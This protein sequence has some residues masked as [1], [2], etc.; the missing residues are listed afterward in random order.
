MNL[1]PRV[2]WARISMCRMEMGTSTETCRTITI[3]LVTQG[4]EVFG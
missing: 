2:G 4:R 1:R 3:T